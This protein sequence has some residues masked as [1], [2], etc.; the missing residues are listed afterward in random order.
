MYKRQNQCCPDFNSDKRIEE[1]A[2]EKLKIERQLETIKGKLPNLTAQI[3]E[4][5]GKLEQL[6]ALLATCF[7]EQLNCTTNTPCTTHEEDGSKDKTY[8]KYIEARKKIQLSSEKCCKKTNVKLERIRKRINKDIRRSERKCERLT[9]LLNDLHEEQS[10]LNDTLKG[11]DKQREIVAYY[12]DVDTCSSYLHEVCYLTEEE[13]IYNHSIPSKAAIEA[14]YSALLNANKVIAPILRPDEVYTL[15][16]ETLEKVGST[17]HK[18]TRYFPFTT[19]GPIGHFSL[20]HLSVKLKD[21]YKLDASG[22]PLEKDPITSETISKD[23]DPRIEIPENNLKFYLD[24]NRCFPNPNGNILNQKPLYFESP[25]IQLFFNQPYV[26]HFFGKWPPYKGLQEKESKLEIVIKDPTENGIA[27]TAPVSNQNTTVLTTLPITNIQWKE[28]AFF[29]ESKPL[30]ILNDLRNPKRKNVDF[31][32]QACWQIGGDPIKPYTEKPEI[33]VEN[34]LPSKLYNA[35]VFNDYSKD[36]IMYDREQ[37]HS[38]PFQTSRYGSISDHIGSYHQKN[39]EGEQKDAVYDALN[40]KDLQLDVRKD[41]KPLFQMVLGIDEAYP[42]D[43]DQELITTYP[44]VYQRAIDGYLEL[45]DIASPLTTEFNILRNA[46]YHIIG[47]WIRTLEPINDPR[48]P[49]EKLFDSIKVIFNGTEKTMAK[50]EVGLFKSSFQDVDK[51]IDTILD[52]PIPFNFATIF[53]KDRSSAL[54][55]PTAPITNAP[56]LKLKF[57]YLTWDGNSYIEKQTYTTGKLI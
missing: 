53:S 3:E 17:Q 48:I 10:K 56:D 23:Y 35:V 34:L 11:L 16:V 38:Y 55:I 43:I 30:S 7:Q 44:D 13:V 26:K 25:E 47:I 45:K 2:K 18:N 46:S 5:C 57:S 50:K 29:K 41:L 14:D 31:D 12:E 42:N 21:Q 52:N 8:Q 24:M 27:N 33:K 1:I 9:T 19:K 32:G 28:D 39:D 51:F 6:R 4:N 49:F 22:K 36:M 20:A 37:I 40:Y 54:I 15:L